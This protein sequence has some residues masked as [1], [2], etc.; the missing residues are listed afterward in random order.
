MKQH[1]KSRG[2]AFAQKDPMVDEEAEDELAGLGIYSTPVTI[3]DG[4]VVMGYDAA[5]LDTLLDN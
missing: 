1:L 2:V 5:R 4:E 3:I